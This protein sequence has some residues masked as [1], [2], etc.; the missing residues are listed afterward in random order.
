MNNLLKLKWPLLALLMVSI[1]SGCGNDDEGPNP[2]DLIASFQYEVSP[3]NF[4]EVSFQNFSQNAASYSWDFGDGNSSTEEN[5]THTY[6]QTGDYT[7]VLTATDA[8]GKT[9]NREETINIQDPEATLT[10]LAGTTSKTWY[11]QREGIALGIGPALNDNQWWSFGGATPLGDRPCILDD[12][13]T[14]HRDGTFEFNSNGTLF[15]DSE[16]NGGWQGP[17][18]AEGCYDESDPGTLMAATGE[19][20]SAFGNGGSYTFDLDADQNLLTLNGLGAYIGLANKTSAGDNYIPISVKEYKIF[21]FVDGD[22]ADSLQI[23][24][25]GDGD[26]FFWNF[27]LVSYDD[28]NDLPDI[29]S[30]MPKASFSFERDGFEVTFDNNSTNATSF[31]WDFGDGN[32]SSEVSPVHTYMNEGDY[33]VTLTAMDGNG[34]SDE[35]MATISVSAAVFSAAVLSDADGKIWKLN[36]EASYVVGPCAGC[37]DWWPGLDAQGVI[38]RACQMDDEFIF[39]DGGTFEYDSKGMVW[40]E[41]YI[42]GPNVCEAESALMSPYDVLG[43]GTH[44]FEVTEAVGMDPATIKVIGTG[45]FIGF[46][47]AFN[48]G[49]LNSTNGVGPASEITYTVHDYSST[50]AG[51][52]LTLVI[53]ISPDGTAW[54]TITMFSEK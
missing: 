10:L 21:N 34:N 29:P 14:F 11:L 9:A 27:Y 6:A 5:P 37:N 39:T 1:A 51:E 18:A 23:A 3:T 20:L 46:H 2:G 44:S 38:D 33:T 16:G 42:G 45:A 4:L 36:G 50:P 35:A 26:A 7:V 22:V 25:V 40:H 30:A 43:S 12:A 17:T 49:E 8:S 53:D 15:I 47:K 24:I 41:D 19:D 54:W 31:M 28:P 32:S 52:T 13:Y 48:G